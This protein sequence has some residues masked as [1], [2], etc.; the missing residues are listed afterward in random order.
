MV[1]EVQGLAEWQQP[2]AGMFIWLKLLAGIQDVDDIA[3]ELVQA[4]VMVLPG[5]APTPPDLCHVS[6]IHQ[7]K[8]GPKLMP[9]MDWGPL[10]AVACFVVQA[11][12]EVCP[13]PSATLH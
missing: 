10:A 4:N 7:A 9:C 11:V 13:E 6:C 12:L 3:A 8:M 2:K 5:A 1:Q